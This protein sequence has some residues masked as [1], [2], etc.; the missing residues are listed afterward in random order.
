MRGR[1]RPFHLARD[2]RENV[3]GK[4][5]CQITDNPSEYKP[6]I[7]LVDFPS[8]G[9][10]TS[11]FSWIAKRPVELLSEGELD[12]C[13][14]LHSGMR[15]V[16]GIYEQYALDPDETRSIAA[17]LK[18]KHPSVQGRDVVM[19]TDFLIDEEIDGIRQRR[20]ISF[21]REEDL[22]H[23]IAEKLE[24]ERR[25][26]AARNTAWSLLL[27]SDLP[28]VV[29]ENM[30]VLFDWYSPEKVACNRRQIPLIEAWAIPHLEC[31]GGLSGVCAKCDRDLGLK[32]GTSLGVAYHL[33]VTGV[34]RIDITKP[35]MPRLTF[36]P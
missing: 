23:R 36:K 5:K 35:L 10:R 27:D 8:I 32:A 33:I 28:L 3:V 17:E 11:C 7:G 6:L 21:K 31:C 24:I 2:Y 29:V 15:P 20:A 9:F 30:R 1:Y 19:S 16:V 12:T 18:I 25:F 34:W 13:Y 26:W 22:N 14:V 4:G